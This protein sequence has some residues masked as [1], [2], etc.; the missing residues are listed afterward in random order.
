MKKRFE[1][2]GMERADIQAY[3]MGRTR[4]SLQ[5]NGIVTDLIELLL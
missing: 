5:G 1:A 2:P 3:E 4:L